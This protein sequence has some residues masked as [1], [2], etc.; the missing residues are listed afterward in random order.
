MTA[1]PVLMVLGCSGRVSNTS[2]PDREA[3]GSANDDGGRGGTGVAGDTFTTGGF[4]SNDAGRG[5]VGGGGTGGEVNAPGSGGLAGEGGEAPICESGFALCVGHAECTDL[6]VGDPQGKTAANC[7]TCGTTCS[8]QHASEAACVDRFCSPTCQSGFANCNGKIANAPNDGC[9]T[10]LSTVQNCGA[11]QYACSQSGATSRGCS[12]GKCAPKC[13]P[14]YANCNESSELASDD[15]CETYLDRLD[16]C[17]SDCSATVACDPTQVCND[18][19]CAAPSGV[20]VLSVPA[21]SA[22]N[23]QTRFSDMFPKPVNLQGATVTLR[24][25]APGASGELTLYM[26]D[27]ASGFSKSV[28]VDLASIAQKWTDVPVTLAGGTAMAADPTGIKQ[29]N[30]VVL[31]NTSA[32]TVLYVDSIRSNNLTIND[33]FDSSFG[34]FAKSSLVTANGATLSWSQ[35]IP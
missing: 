35:S 6:H 9:E 21:N 14:R 30:L 33:T 15:G 13:A 28:I 29:V 19:A 26:S 8:L 11:C 18:G 17:G 3:G 22:S 12:A 16:H 4:V 27:Q 20:V 2:P 1:L 5:P 23:N 10:D 24:L 25:Y 34:N 31:P 7:G 32:A